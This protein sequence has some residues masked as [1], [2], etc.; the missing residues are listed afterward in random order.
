MIKPAD[1]G[2]GMVWDVKTTT[3][4]DADGQVFQVIM[5]DVDT[6]VD[7]TS[8][9]LTF[10]FAYD[11]EGVRTQ[12]TYPSGAVRVF[13]DD[14]ELPSVVTSAFTETR[15][16]EGR[17]TS[18]VKPEGTID[19]GWDAAGGLASNHGMQRGQDTRRPDP[20]ASISAPKGPAING[21][22]LCDVLVH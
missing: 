19:Y 14:P 22:C 1:S 10:T 11:A 8:E 17:L 2:T 13:A 21:R 4:F 16:S 12:V 3:V 9:D 6:V 5:N 18:R 15:D 20:A 7:A